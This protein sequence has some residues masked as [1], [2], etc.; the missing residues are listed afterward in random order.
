MLTFLD[1]CLIL[2]PLFW[3]P[4]GQSLPDTFQMPIPQSCTPK[5]TWKHFE[6][7]KQSLQKLIVEEECYVDAEILPI[8]HTKCTMCQKRL[9]IS[10]ID[11]KSFFAMQEMK[12]HEWISNL[13]THQYIHRINFP[14]FQP[15]SSN[16][17][18]VFF[19][20]GKSE[21]YCNLNLFRFPSWNF[22]G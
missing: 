20:H 4:S 16:F 15:T 6:L 19:V 8:S 17:G 9:D 10:I 18:N 5:K 1:S 3:L 21:L 12:T 7:G 22:Y 11:W 2:H 14:L 13:E